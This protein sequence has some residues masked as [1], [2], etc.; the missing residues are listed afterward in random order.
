MMTDVACFCGCC[1][2]FEG[3]AAACPSCGDVA[4]VTAGRALEDDGRSQPKM[5][6]P[7]L[8]AI[9]QNGQPLEACLGRAQAGFLSGRLLPAHSQN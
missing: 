5:P 4:S 6:V 2:S 7:V 3:G 9:G 8:K 1:F